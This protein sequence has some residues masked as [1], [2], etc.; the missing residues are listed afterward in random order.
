M[1]TLDSLKEVGYQVI[2]TAW[3]H[4]L[5]EGFTSLMDLVDFAH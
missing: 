5:A 2:K 3:L 1:F 4:S